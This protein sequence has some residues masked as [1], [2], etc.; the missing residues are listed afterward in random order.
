MS[1]R[2]TS[3]PYIHSLYSVIDGLCSMWSLR[4]TSYV[5]ILLPTHVKKDFTQSILYMREQIVVNLGNP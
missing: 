4:I 5:L 2:T 3:K 1:S